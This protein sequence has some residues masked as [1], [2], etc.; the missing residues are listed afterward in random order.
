MGWITQSFGWPYV[1][2]V[3]GAIG[4]VFTFVWLRVIYNPREHPLINQAEIDHIERG[5]GLVDMDQARKE[6]GK[7]EGPS[8][9]I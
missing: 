7:S 8:C 4:I 6:G 3:M 2:Y 9:P 5:G 1:F